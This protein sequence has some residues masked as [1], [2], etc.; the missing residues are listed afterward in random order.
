M[1]QET[2]WAGGLYCPCVVP[3]HPHGLQEFRQQVLQVSRHW[4]DQLIRPEVCTSYTSFL[5]HALWGGGWA[6]DG[7][8]GEAL[9]HPYSQSQAGLC[10]PQWPPDCAHLFWLCFLCLWED[11][12]IL[13]LES[14]GRERQEEAN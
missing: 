13:E 8:E 6:R 5:A 4:Q 10:L 11:F 9:S 7:S 2:G 3:P 14:A 1:Y 12:Y